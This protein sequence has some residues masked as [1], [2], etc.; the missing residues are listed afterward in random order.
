MLNE[1]IKQGTKI[2]IFRVVQLYQN[3][4]DREETLVCTGTLH[5]VLSDAKLELLVSDEAESLQKNVCYLIYLY[6]AQRV[7]RCSCYFQ[8]PSYLEEG[9]GISI[10]LAS[11]LQQVQRRMHQR[12]SCRGR[13]CIKVLPDRNAEEYTGEG[14][15]VRYG[16][17]EADGYGLW[18]ETMIDI[19]G[20]G[21]R[22]ASKKKLDR[23]TEIL[24]KF[25][26]FCEAGQHEMEVAGRVVYSEVLRNEND[27]YDIR[28]KY[29][30]L[31][32]EKR[33]QIIRY[34]FQLERKNGR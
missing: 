21:I 11:P 9:T 28:M 19:S 15:P 26:F 7:Y 33:E 12:V 17:E 3:A 5:K 23:G 34:V 10:E 16:E 31:T 18:E 20:G 27:Y 6:F 30:Y 22:F 13:I 25:D 24:I 1:I 29:I 4:A 14:Q 2:K 8:A 32:E